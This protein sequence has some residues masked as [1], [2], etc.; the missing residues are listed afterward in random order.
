M[1]KKERKQKRRKRRVQDL[2]H[3]SD[4]IRAKCVPMLG[5]CLCWIKGGKLKGGSSG[6]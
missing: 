1:E 6:S 2:F 5:V 3:T 4:K